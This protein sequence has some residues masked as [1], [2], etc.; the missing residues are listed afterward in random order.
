LLIKAKE[1][2]KFK[3]PYLSLLELWNTLKSD[4]LGSSEL[5]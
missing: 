2:K 3:D 4:L 1:D 5:G